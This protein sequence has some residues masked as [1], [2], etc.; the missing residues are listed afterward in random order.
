LGSGRSFRGQSHETIPLLFHW[1]YGQSSVVSPR[2]TWIAHALSCTA[3]AVITT[4]IPLPL[5][6]DT[7]FS[8]WMLNP[9][10]VAMCMVPSG[11]VDTSDVVTLT[12]ASTV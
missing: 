10:L 11:S 7:V 9:E 2:P 3:L 8:E 6:N 5:A 4:W 1:L 12:G